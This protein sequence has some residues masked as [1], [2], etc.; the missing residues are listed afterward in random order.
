VFVNTACRSKAHYLTPTIEVTASNSGLEPKS[1]LSECLA[2]IRI[3]DGLGHRFTRNVLWS[4]LGT[5]ASQSFTLISSAC[6]ARI[7]GRIPYGQLGIV[8]STLTMFGTFAGFGL[9]ITATR[10]VA[11]LRTVDPPRARRILGLSSLTAALTGSL[12]GL[13]LIGLAPWLTQ[14]LPGVR[15][16]ITPLRYG[17]LWLAFL[18]FN[19][20]QN[21]SLSGLEAFHVIAK[22]N[23]LRGVLTVPAVIIGAMVWGVPGVMAA[24][25]CVAGIIC[26]CTARSLSVHCRAINLRPVFRSALSEISVLWRF[27]FPAVL[28]GC[29][30]GPITWATHMLLLSNKTGFSEMAII[31]IATQ[32]RAAIMFLP[33]TLAQPFLAML[34]G[35]RAQNNRFQGSSLL[36]WTLLSV[37]ILSAVPAIAVV[38]L[39]P[40]ILRAYGPGYT[41][42]TPI[43]G[44]YAMVAVISSIANVIGHVIVSDGQ[45]WPGFAL[46]A[47]WAAALLGFS[48]ILVPTRGAMGLAES[49]LLAYG[50]HGITVYVYARRCVWD[51][52]TRTK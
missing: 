16:L 37:A 49:M 27:S 20:A 34:T 7:L 31:T 51:V 19:G 11:E 28:A 42:G 45:M 43:L 9:G 14:T 35:I 13:A 24:T 5:V 38:L 2:A 22:L 8:Q 48:F 18:A 50:L 26:I 12:L 10:Y 21:G 4:A 15:E 39:S 1:R 46:N 33:S 44:L 32:W 40:L 17:A 36:K 3:G 52:N 25:A 41:D 6:A 29:L 23:I 47:L 30:V